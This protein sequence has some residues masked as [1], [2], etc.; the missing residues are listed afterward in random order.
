[1]H[2]QCYQLRCGLE[3]IHENALAGNQKLLNWLLNRTMQIHQAID[4]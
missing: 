2:L 4:N 1:V 3:E